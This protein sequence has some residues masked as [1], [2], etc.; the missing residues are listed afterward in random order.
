VAYNATERSEDAN[1][2]IEETYRRFPT[3]LFA[4]TNYG[5]VRITQGHPEDVPK[6]LGGNFLLHRVQEGRTRFHIS[7]AVSFFG[8]LGHYFLAIHQPK[9]AA[10]YLDILEKIAPDHPMTQQ[11]RSQMLLAMAEMTYG[12]RFETT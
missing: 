7:E 6:I 5:M 3:Y 9:Q 2:I 10:V 8:L 11:V 1:R 4:I 12:H